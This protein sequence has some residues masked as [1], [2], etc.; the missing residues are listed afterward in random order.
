MT[1]CHLSRS[2]KTWQ[3][4]VDWG[5]Q[6]VILEKVSLF[7][8]SIFIYLTVSGLLCGTQ[9]LFSCGTWTLSWG[10]WDLVLWPWIEPGPLHW[11]LSVL[12]IGSPGKCPRENGWYS[13][14][15]SLKVKCK[16]IQES[17]KV[18]FEFSNYWKDY[19]V[20]RRAVFKLWVS[21]SVGALILRNRA[22]VLAAW[23]FIHVPQENN[24]CKSINRQIHLPIN[25]SRVVKR[26]YPYQILKFIMKSQ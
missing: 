18:I 19:L 16:S 17:N 24:Q 22:Q 25:F 4:N 23:A 5:N 14:A 6:K 11:E 7:L 8:F 10:M 13:E 26:H 2:L 12:A 1:S 9:Y 3:V 21:E 15:K 20:S